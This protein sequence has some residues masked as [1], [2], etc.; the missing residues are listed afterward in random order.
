M[1]KAFVMKEMIRRVAM[2]LAVLMLTA[3]EVGAENVTFT[4]HSWNGSQVVTTTDTKD[5]TVL[6]GDHAKDW[7]GLYDGYYVVKTDTK[8]RVLNILGDAHLILS[9]GATL[10]C[11]HVKLEGTNKLH[12][13]ADSESGTGK[14]KVENYRIE[15][16]YSVD[17]MFSQSYV[18]I[19]KNAAGIGSGGG[20]VNMGSLYVHGGVV[21][22][23]SY[24]K[25]AAIGGGDDGCIGGEVIIYGG[26][27]KAESFAKSPSG[28]GI[29]GGYGTSQGNPIL[30]YG[31]EVH[32]DGG[33][34]SAAIGGGE[35]G[36]H[37]GYVAIYGG[38]VKALCGSSAA[39]IGGGSDGKGGEVHFFGG[40]IALY[41]GNNGRAVGGEESLGVLQIADNLK[42]S[43][44]SA[45]DETPERVFTNGERVPACHWRTYAKIEA[46]S[47]E[48]PTVGSDKNEAI[49]Y[50]IDDAIY[51]TKHCRYC[52]V[53]VQ[54]KHANEN[55]V[56]GVKDGTYEFTIYE[57]GTEKNTYVK[58]TTR[59]VGAGKKFY[60]PE[61]TNV[62]AGY[63]F[64]GWEMNP[65][66]E[67]GNEWAAKLGEDIKEVGESVTALLGQDETSFYARFIYDLGWVT[68]WDNNSPTTG[69]RVHISHDDI[70]P[71]TLKPGNYSNSSLTIDFEDLEDDNDNVFGT[72]YVARATYILNGY[73]YTY[74]GIKDVISLGDNA[75]N[76]SALAKVHSHTADVTLSG[77][78]LFRDGFWNTLCLPFNVTI[79][80]SPLAG[81]EAR[82][83]SSASIEDG[84]L[85]LTFSEPVA[86]IPA[87]TPFIIKWAKDTSITDPVFEGTT[88]KATA[89]TEVAFDGIKFVG[90]YAPFDIT[91][92]NKDNILYIGSANKIGHSKNAR[93]LKSC[94]AHFELTDPAAAPV[95]TVVMECGEGEIVT[96]IESVDSGELTVD[97][98]W[99]LSGVQLNGKPSEKGVYLFNGK[100]VVIQ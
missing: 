44:G 97:S 34:K 49:T 93:T 84:T 89:S 86:T 99:T 36:G 32:A 52:N 38:N 57:P 26:K 53:T 15:L 72:H 25:G 95:R 56:C 59:T 29:G 31:G 90:S 30:I 67:D 16:T 13:Y 77:R 78:T 41:A 20:G 22:V 11:A 10:E 79:A 45:K 64:K 18:P 1:K 47:H 73:E 43:A 80:D 6:E 23:V 91:A 70:T 55:C 21:D 24:S 60:L 14:L 69:T 27:V 9:D 92:E 100:K 88:I 17:G 94:R 87:G 85:N 82:T 39:C 46:C 81:G 66:P 83:L 68:E 96:E 65:D 76:S 98:W 12:I 19:Y 2:T 62:P 4:V 5:A 33:G 3:I 35:S 48:T 8:Y 37:G 71:W 58:G 50:S 7:I 28:A 75:D 42:V 40:T 74:D 54:E 51:H 61:C 63:I